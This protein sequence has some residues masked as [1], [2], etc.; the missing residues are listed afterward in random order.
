M[1]EE[2]TPVDVGT[3]EVEVT[4]VEESPIVE[5]SDRTVEE[6]AEREFGATEGDAAPEA[7]D[8]ELE[9]VAPDDGEQVD[10]KVYTA[11]I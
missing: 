5:P 4:P 3:P 10:T 2:A 11:R 7:T 6:S 9:E 1:S 8:A